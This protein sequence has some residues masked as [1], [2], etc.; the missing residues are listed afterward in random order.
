MTMQ[1]LR[2]LIVDDNPSDR[3]MVIQ[4]LRRAFPDARIEEAIDQDQLE[5]HLSSGG[6]D[7][8]IT[9]YHLRWSDG[10]RVLSTVKAVSPY[11]PVIMFTATGSQEI[12][13]EAMKRGLDDYIVKSVKH[14][15]RLRA[16]VQSVIEKAR[17]RSRAD[18]LAAKL[19]SLLS[20]L[21]LGAFS[22]AIDGTLLEY[23]DAIKDILDRDLEND[24]ARKN[25]VS[26]FPDRQQ[27]VNFIE[28]ILKTHGSEE[29]DL[30]IGP[31]GLKRCFRVRAQ[32]VAPSLNGPTIDGLIEDVT[33]RKRSEGES[34]LA[35][36]V[37]ARIATLSPREKQVFL[38]VVEGAPNKL[39]ARRLDIS[40]KTVEKHRSNLMRKMCAAN[41]AEL[42]RT[43]TLAEQSRPFQGMTKN[44]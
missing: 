37:N 14:L 28:R 29:I 42:V 31:D 12:A 7:V 24:V 10:L 1:P 2:V 3:S 36:V 41:F 33:E 39:I 30:E 25:L 34:E 6:F 27:G 22:C 26:L 44:R 32:W 19:D 21:Q 43:A 4:E 40:E 9:D 20:Q 38:Q 23:N 18:H 5:R 16:S 13:V 35:A 8:V 17:M 11:C 15:I